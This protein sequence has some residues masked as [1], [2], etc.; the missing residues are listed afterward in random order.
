[1]KTFNELRKLDVGEHI[2]KKNGLSY[3]SWSWAV[4]VLLQNDPSATWEFPEP[5]YYGDTVM[6]Y[7]DV[8]AFGKTM[9]MH[10]PVMD[11]RNKA[12]VNP[13]TTDINKAM[14]RCLAKCIACFGIGLY[15]F[16]GEDLPTESVEDQEVKIESLQSY[17]DHIRGAENVN[18]LKV[19]WQDAITA[20]G[21]SLEL[22]KMINEEVKQRKAMLE[23]YA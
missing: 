10:L 13:N 22:K 2:E 11:L 6:V 19:I 5:K 16:S 4:D 8:T 7:C 23:K 9:K 3:L 1:M 20:C 17:L 18:E 14:M 21:N 15:I 12:I